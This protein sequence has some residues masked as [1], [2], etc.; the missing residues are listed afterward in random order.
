MHAQ[1]TVFFHDRPVRR[2]LL[3]PDARYGLG[4]EAACDI[5]LDDARISRRHAVF[6]CHDGA[7]QCRDL[8]SKNGIRINGHVIE[9]ARLAG[10]EWLDLG[11]LVARFALVDESERTALIAHDER[12]RQTSVQVA[13]RIDPQRGIRVLLDDILDAVLELAG[14]RR[15][16]M[17][18]DN[19]NDDFEM[20]AS[21]GIAWIDVEGSGFS[22]SLGVVRD[23]LSRSTAIVSCD[24][25][26][27][28]D[29]AER[30]SIA[31]PGIRALACLPLRIN[32][33]RNGVIYTDS[34]EPGKVFD[35]LDLE[36]LNG[37]AEHA[38]LAIAAALLRDSLH[39]MAAGIPDAAAPVTL[40]GL[41]AAH[42]SSHQE[43]A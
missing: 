28:T 33:A 35:E 18:L 15:A 30:P 25:G 14:T 13:R 8:G 32:D 6:D 42:G 37:F 31:G 38:G 23:V 36:I 41:L 7:W 21:R 17:M 3:D 26:T 1:L 4:R 39:E 9:T 34:D 19:G 10:D 29:Y 43:R 11:G 22:G 40:N 2:F 16:F 5:F 24:I 20:F 27:H 12:R